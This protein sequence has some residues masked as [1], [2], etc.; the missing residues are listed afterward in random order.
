M[1]GTLGT[2]YGV[3]VGPGD[4]ELLTRKAERVLRS[5]ESIF[6]PAG[7]GGRKGFAAQ[8]VE[9]LGLPSVKF[10][11]VKLCMNRDRGEDDRTYG[12]TAAAIINELGS[13]RSAA[14]ITEGDPSIY[15]TF[16]HLLDHV[17][18]RLPG[19]PVEIVPGVSSL[20]AA[21]ARAV[22]P[23]ALLDERLAVLPAAY[24]LQGLEDL[25]ARFTTL[26]L[27]KV[28]S[29]LAPLVERLQRLPGTFRV[30]YVEKAGT[31]EEC[32]ITDPKM[33]QGADAS[34]FSLVIVRRE[35][36]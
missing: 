1:N 31:A 22:I 2:F 19:A 8:I 33:I 3:G 29:V 13:G 9:P 11:P 20:N 21:A 15:S 4:P 30:V 32:V 16:W 12:E 6:C 23:L 36:P 14:W 7:P 10:R 27:F 35:H 24:G 34:Y 25:M 28:H 26:V 18:R 5:V 17:R